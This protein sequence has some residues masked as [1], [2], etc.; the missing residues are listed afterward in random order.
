VFRFRPRSWI[1]FLGARINVAIKATVAPVT[2]PNRPPLGP[3]LQ[4]QTNCRCQSICTPTPT[5]GHA[6]CQRRPLRPRL[7]DNEWSAMV[8][9]LDGW[10]VENGRVEWAKTSL[11]MHNILISTMAVPSPGYCGPSIAKDK[12]RQNAAEWGRWATE[13]YGALH[14]DT[15]I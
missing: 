4:V 13:G 10:M 9:W 15:S 3:N 7:S 2:W 6:P 5:K 11:R 8:E 1:L 12:K 14:R